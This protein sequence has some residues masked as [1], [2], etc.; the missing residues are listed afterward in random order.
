MDA[1]SIF[2]SQQHTAKQPSADTS[3]CPLCGRDNRCA[4]AAAGC[5]DDAT[6]CWCFTVSIPEQLLTRIPSELRGKA[7]VCPACVEAFY[8]EQH[9]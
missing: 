6:G 2:N 1:N 9:S 4:C 3:R 5:P 7:C 8:K